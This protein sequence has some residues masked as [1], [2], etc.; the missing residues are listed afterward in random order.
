MKSPRWFFF[1][2][3]TL[4]LCLPQSG[5]LLAQSAAD[6]F[7]EN[8]LKISGS[9]S[10]DQASVTATG[11]GSMTGTVV[12][13]PYLN[14]RDAVWG[15]IIGA[16]YNGNKVEIVGSSGD[17]YKINYGSGIAFVHSDYVV[18]DGSSAAA[19]SSSSSGTPGVV[20]VNPSLNIRTSPWGAVIGSFYEGDKVTIVG[21]EGDWYKISLNGK[22]VYCHSDYI[23]KSGGAPASTP[24]SQPTTGTS[25]VQTGANGKV[26]LN[27]PK[28]CQGAV[29]CPVPWSACGPTSLGMAL[30]YYGKGNAGSLASSLWYT[31][32]TTGAAGTNHAGLVKGAKQHGFP[33]ARWN[34][35]VGLS[36]VKEQI[37]AGK[38]VIANVYNHYV[39][40]TGVDDSGNIYY[41]DP[42]KWDV[43]QVKSYD[44]FSAWW[45]GGG[46]YHA[47]MTLQ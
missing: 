29:S 21:Q 14:V 47:A 39:V 33:N 11:K 32:G 20:H 38:P 26:V 9:S 27:V 46:C 34:Y 41:N 18:I 23:T 8:A 19:S 15:N 43:V 16:L 25:G 44:S 1:W 37:K 5:P 4:A 40:I 3:L 45:N 6:V 36:W 17:W 7:G 30:A 35:S 31:C 22:I 2:L 42:A 10:T 13:S 28:Q 24:S 12:V